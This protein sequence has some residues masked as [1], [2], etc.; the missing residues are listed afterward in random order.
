MSN[1]N[2]S[3]E[4]IAELA[5]ENYKNGNLHDAEKLFYDVL[6]ISPNHFFSLFLLGTI[7][8]QLNKYQD[9]IK[10]FQETIKINP[11][12]KETQNNLGNIF[13]EL[14]QYEEAE[15]C[16]K[17]AI[18]IDENFVDAN[19]NYGNFLE[20]IG[21]NKD[22]LLYY[23][24]T[25][26]LDPGYI[27]AHYNLG[28]V[29]EKLRELEKAIS[30][31]KKVIQ[32]NPDF[33]LAYIGLGILYRGAGEIKKAIIYFEK[34]IEIDPKNLNAH[35]LNMNSFPIVYE[36]TEE[37]NLYRKRFEENIKKIDKLI[38]NN[39]KYTKNEILEAVQSSTNF[40]LTYQGKDDLY[41]QKNYAQLLERL[42]NIVY[43]ELNV[44][45]NNSKSKNIRIGF[46]S[47]N[48][49]FHSIT[50]TFKSWVLNLD[51]KLFSS[52]VYYVGNK[53]DEAT[54][55]IKKIA[56]NFFNHTHI[57]QLINRIS[58]DKLDALIYFDIGMNPK[59]QILGS[60]RLAPIQC[61]TWGHPTT[62]GLKN[63]D[64][65]FS[66]ELIEF[67]NSQKQYSEKLITLP[68]IGTNYEPPALLNTKSSNFTKA[69]KVIF[70]S[71]HSLF[72]IVPGDDH[73]FFDI[74]KDV[75]NCQ[76]WFFES[77][78]TK[79]T[80]IFKSRLLKLCEKAG[81]VFN[82]YFFFIPRCSYQ[83]FLCFIAQADI[84]LDS[85]SFS[86]FN[87]AIEALNLNKPVITL[88]GILMKQRLAYSVL[89]TI[90]VY[91]TIADSKKNYVDISIKL[92]RDN[93]FRSLVI[94]KINSNKSKIF[95]N[96]K[97]IRFIEDF[98]KKKIKI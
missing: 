69:N 80:S 72:K 15:H 6:K 60:L 44:E 83:E 14:G 24:K 16:Y 9:A 29:Y 21:K 92:A 18:D 38:D 57:D 45:I 1:E 73:I 46:V 65:F 5:F 43:P 2:L 23:K 96:D 4:K 8:A 7:S 53:F 42:T 78:E 34:A 51:E 91:E 95:N 55:Q 52:Y 75:P 70:L 22:A 11:N 26:E 20:K 93:E 88:P 47:S 85:L 3:V 74:L 86:G 41:L 17:K 71:Y 25:I 81:I 35:W 76:F 48:L 31:Y 90:S 89:K 49:I 63:I 36:K 54:N 87:T 13:N 98:F 59:I 97:S 40:Y 28:N 39:R 19:Y 37:L 33:I 30:S 67:K 68:G 27:K 58:S 66:S 61:V 77:T 56:N 10:F 62:S 84:V 50:K 32:I 12:Y 82:K 94:K 79:A 64:Y